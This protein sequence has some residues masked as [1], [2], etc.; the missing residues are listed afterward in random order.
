MTATALIKTHLSFINLCQQD[1]SP[2]TTPRAK[3]LPLHAGHTQVGP[4]PEPPVTM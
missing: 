4:T 1:Q 3:P 2:C